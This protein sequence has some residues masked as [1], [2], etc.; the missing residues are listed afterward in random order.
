MEWHATEEALL[1]AMVACVQS[2]DPDIILGF[3]VQQG[4]LGYL[5]DRA[6]QSDRPLLR[7]LS[8]TPEVGPASDEKRCLH[9]IS[10]QP[11]VRRSSDASEARPAVCS[12]TIP[13]D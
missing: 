3:E 11:P 6:G 7:Q 9:T 13:A 5:V 8:R 1:D 4:S 2:L 12:V 10:L